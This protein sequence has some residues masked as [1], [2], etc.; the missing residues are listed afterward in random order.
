M[1]VIVIIGLL[2]AIATPMFIRYREHAQKEICIENLEQ[3]E[4]A[5]QQWGLQT[6]QEADATPAAAEIFGSDKWIKVAPLCP[7]GGLYVLGALDLS[8]TC[9]LAAEGHEIQ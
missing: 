5:K 4:S 3:I 9:T 1:I 6:G 2:L 8:A 7:G